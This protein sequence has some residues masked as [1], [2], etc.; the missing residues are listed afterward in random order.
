MPVLI[1]TKHD[2][3]VALLKNE[4]LRILRSPVEVTGAIQENQ[5]A[6]DDYYIVA[7]HRG[8]VSRITSIDSMSKLLN[9][10][11][12]V[13]FVSCRRDKF[14]NKKRSF[15]WLNCSE[16]YF[17]QDV[18]NEAVPVIGEKHILN[19][20]DLSTINP[21]VTSIEV[22]RPESEGVSSSEVVFYRNPPLYH[23]C[24]RVYTTTS[25]DVVPVDDGKNR[26][27]VI[28]PDDEAFE[29]TI[30]ERFKTAY[31]PE[32]LDVSPV[33][34]F[35]VGY[36]P[37]LDRQLHPKKLLQLTQEC[38]EDF[39]RKIKVPP[40]PIDIAVID[41]FLGEVVAREIIGNDDPE[42]TTPTNIK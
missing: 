27:Q 40:K 36:I 24:K 22:I 41:V 10:G 33:S 42:T 39:S 1:S 26:V 21:G 28:Y 30:I 7:G 38:F 17:R 3:V 13:L 6:E 15:R 5:L 35:K 8:E 23:L 12:V 29:D 9:G 18:F 11:A 25:L 37:Y 19:A 16:G 2:I 31:V 32:S 34:G 20:A 4:E 14:G